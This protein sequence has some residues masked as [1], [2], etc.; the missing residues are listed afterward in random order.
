MAAIARLQ[1]VSE[2]VRAGR[3]VGCDGLIFTVDRPAVHDAEAVVPDPLERGLLDGIDSG[4]ARRVLSQRGGERL[5]RTRVALDLDDHCSGGVAHGAAE[6]ETGR[7]VPHERT[8]PDPLHHAVHREPQPFT[9]ATSG[10][11][12]TRRAGRGW[13][14]RDAHNITRRAC[15]PPSS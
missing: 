8:E 15:A 3:G 4:E 12:G 2:A 6:P 13:L 14:G 7:E 5:E 10:C 1:D 11:G 9:R